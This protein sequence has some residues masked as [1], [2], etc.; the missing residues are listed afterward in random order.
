VAKHDGNGWVDCCCG[1]RHW[2]LYGAAGL[3]LIRTDED[4][5]RLLLQLRAEWTHEGGTWGLP[6]G[7]RDSHE[8][9]VT[10]ALRE[11]AEETGIDPGQIRVLGR[12]PGTEH[13]QWS[14]TYVLALAEDLSSVAAPNAEGVELRWV[15][16]EEVDSLPL[17]PALR[18]TWPT[19]FRELSHRIR[20]R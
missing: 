5:V 15:P 1:R 8:D 4:T 19:L 20:H 6:G 17:H 18:N 16:L 3:A 14:Y 11:A 12:C 7:A 9:A 13:G 10:T 2:G